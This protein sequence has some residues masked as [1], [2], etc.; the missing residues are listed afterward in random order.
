MSSSVPRPHVVVSSKGDIA[1]VAANKP[2]LAAQLARPVISVVSNTQSNDFSKREASSALNG[3]QMKQIRFV[4]GNGELVIIQQATTSVIE[5]GAKEKSLDT[6]QSSTNDVLE[7]ET[8]A[9]DETTS[10]IDEGEEDEEMEAG[11]SSTNQS[12]SNVDS[13]KT[14]VVV[15]VEE[16]LV[17]FEA[18]TVAKSS[19]SIS[20]NEEEERLPAQNGSDH[21]NGSDEHLVLNG[22]G[23]E[24]DHDEATV[25]ELNENGPLLN[26][27]LPSNHVNGCIKPTREEE[28]EEKPLLNGLIKKTKSKAKKRSAPPPQDSDKSPDL[29]KHKATPKK[30]AQKNGYIERRESEKSLAPT[31]I[32]QTYARV[33]Q[34]MCEWDACT[35]F[36]HSGTAMIY[37]VLHSHINRKEGESSIEQAPS[38]SNQST[39]SIDLLYCRWPGCE[40]TP[41]SRWSLITHLQENHC[42]ENALNSA[43]RKRREIGDSNYVA[44]IRQKLQ[45]VTSTINHPGYTKFA[46][47]DAIRRHAFNFMPRDITV[48]I[49]FNPSVYSKHIS[50]RTSRRS[51]NKRFASDERSHIEKY[52]Q[53]LCRV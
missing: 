18:T 27:T 4:N 42:N 26:G 13:I 30:K 20:E 53:E 39:S 9:A 10:T 24:G 23:K 48:I 43:T 22:V 7:D 1:S 40:R 32:Q 6:Q 46:A 38:T 52:G 41:R 37:H 45:E 11:G 50:G 31:S 28:S 25:E 14:A 35:N 33:P 34:F 15:A 29:K 49:S 21:P 8:P 12:T 36:F 17:Q 5:G 2:A 44:A 51:C 19:P 47:Y 3:S 16:D